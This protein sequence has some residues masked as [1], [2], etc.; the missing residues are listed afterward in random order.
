VQ[1]CGATAVVVVTVVVEP[2]PHAQ[3][4]LPSAITPAT[5]NARLTTLIRAQRCWRSARAR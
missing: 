3:T 1:C 4:A 5:E 2:P